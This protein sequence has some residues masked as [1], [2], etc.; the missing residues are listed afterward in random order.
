MTKEEEN[1]CLCEDKKEDI[2]S[3]IIEKKNKKE[4]KK[5][6]KKVANSE[7]H[8]YIPK[9]RAHSFRVHSTPP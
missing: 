4:E 2:R 5:L 6:K 7:F 3:D 1:F 8:T 9:T